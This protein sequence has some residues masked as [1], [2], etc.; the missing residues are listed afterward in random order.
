MKE[1]LG[2]PDT[3]GTAKLDVIPQLI[4]QVQWK[5]STVNSQIVIHHESHESVSMPGPGVCLV[6]EKSVMNNH[7]IS[8][9]FDG[10]PRGTQGGIHRSRNAGDLSVVFQLKPI[11]R[12]GPIFDPTNI[13]EAI[14]M[15][16]QCFQGYRLHPPN[17][18]KPLRSFKLTDCKKSYRWIE[19]HTLTDIVRR[20]CRVIS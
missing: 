18:A 15:L 13:E 3:Q 11:D 5:M 17:E 1:G 7:E 9:H 14:T 12:S 4:M 16:D 2:F 6:P 19:F 10:F 20:S 8:S